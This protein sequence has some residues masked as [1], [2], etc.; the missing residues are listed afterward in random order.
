M[1]RNVV[2]TIY[3]KHSKYEIIKSD[4]GLLGST[5]FAIYRD[6]SHFKG[7]YKSLEDAV[8]AAKKAG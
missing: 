7:S 5:S 2:E 3:G 1:S 6:G 8:E 4:G